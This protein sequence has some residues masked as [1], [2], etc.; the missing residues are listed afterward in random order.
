MFTSQGGQEVLVYSQGQAED[1][2]DYTSY[3][4]KLDKV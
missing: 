4:P 2:F 1:V 3:T